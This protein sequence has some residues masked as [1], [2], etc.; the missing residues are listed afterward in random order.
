MD[1]ASLIFCSAVLSA[2]LAVA[3]LAIPMASVSD[4]TLAKSN[5]VVDSEKVGMMDLGS[6]G[7]VSVKDLTDYYMENP[8]VVTAGAVRKVRFE[9]C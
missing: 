2:S 9:G 6:F 5:A 3:A 7:K 4:K 1:K 8:P